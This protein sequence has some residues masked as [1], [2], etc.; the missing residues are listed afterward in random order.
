[1][2]H[3]SFSSCRK[4]QAYHRIRWAIDCAKRARTRKPSREQNGDIS[5]VQND[6][7]WCTNRSCIVPAVQYG[8]YRAAELQVSVC[9]YFISINKVKSK[10]GFNFH[11]LI[12]FK[13]EIWNLLENLLP[14]FVKPRVS[15]C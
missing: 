11:L 8:L 2:S 10:I 14:E 15:S 7:L 9:N 13:K 6:L 5:R 12:D 3:Q 1:M 4:R